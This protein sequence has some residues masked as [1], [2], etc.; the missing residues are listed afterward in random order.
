MSWFLQENFMNRHL[1][2]FVLAVF[3]QGCYGLVG[4]HV[5]ALQGHKHALGSG[6]N[7]GAVFHFRL[8][9]RLLCNAPLLLG[10]EALDN[11]GRQQHRHD[12]QDEQR[13]LN[14]I[15]YYQG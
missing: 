6:F 9:Q 14:N 2:K 4:I 11:N 15:A 12:H 10:S 3:K 13:N 8:P 7:Q 1:R 5:S